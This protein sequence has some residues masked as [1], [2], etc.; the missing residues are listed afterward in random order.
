MSGR[1][2]RPEDAPAIAALHRLSLF[3]AMPGL[4]DIHTPEEDLAYF[5]D[6]LLPAQTVRVIDGETGLI[7]YAAWAEG[8]LNHLYVH[9][10]HPGEGHGSRLLALAMAEAGAL[11]LWAFQRNARARAFYEA[12]GFTVVRLTDGS[13]NEEQEPDVLYAW[14]RQ[15]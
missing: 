8:W 2:A 3:T 14:S 10:D 13:G 15:D 11:Q 4:A 5:R 1:P 6:V 9:P 7:A 12:R